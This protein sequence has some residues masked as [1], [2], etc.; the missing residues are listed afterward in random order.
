MFESGQRRLPWMASPPTT[1]AGSRGSSSKAGANTGSGSGSGLKPHWVSHVQR[2]ATVQERERAVRRHYKA[3]V[4]R[5]AGLK[6]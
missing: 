5:S 4:A 3:I 6:A 2:K 1:E